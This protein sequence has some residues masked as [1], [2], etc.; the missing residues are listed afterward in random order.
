MQ[1]EMRAQFAT[2]SASV[3]SIEFEM[4]GMARNIS[5]LM[6]QQGKL[7]QPMEVVMQRLSLL[8]EA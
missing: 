6:Q 1:S 4:A 5:L 8:A 2:V 7:S 3:S